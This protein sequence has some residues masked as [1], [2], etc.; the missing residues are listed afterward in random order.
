MKYRKGV[1]IVTFNKNKYL[2]LKRK[3]HWEGW[4]FP[5]G[6]RKEK[7][8]VEKTIKR[9]IKEETGQ[10]PI[11]IIYFNK[12]GSWKYP[13]TLPDRPGIKGM[14]WQLFAAEIKNLKIKLAKEHES[15]KWLSYNQAYKMLTYKNQKTCLKLVNNYLKKIK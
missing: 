5:K 7:E 3:L 6:G 11:T 9:E 13:K 10:K 1:F 15:Y 4:E 14:S 12:T 2:I 8:R